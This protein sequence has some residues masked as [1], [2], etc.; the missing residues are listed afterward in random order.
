MKKAIFS[1]SFFLFI[2]ALALGLIEAGDRLSL[3]ENFTSSTCPPCA[4]NNPILEA[5]M[6][7]VDSEKVIAISYHMNWPTP[8]NDPMY[9]YNVTDNNGRRTFYN[10][11]S[12]PQYWFDGVYNQIGGYSG[13]T[14]TSQLNSRNAISSPVTVILTDSAYATDSVLV[15]VKVWCETY[16]SSPNATLQIAVLENNIAY[17]GTNGEPMHYW[18]M[19]KML[20]SYT[21]TQIQ[22][23]PGNLITIEQRY[24]KDPIWISNNVYNI[25]WVQGVGNEVYC[26]SQKTKNFTLLPYPAF[27]VV[28]QGVAANGSYKIRIPNIKAGY[29]S[30]VTFT[31]EVSP[32]TTGI[33]TSFPNGNVISNF[34]DSISLNVSSTSAVPTGAYKIIV[35]GTNANQKSHKI[36][37]DYLVGKNYVTVATN[38][39]TL[40][41]NVNGIGYYSSN[42]FSWNLGSSQTVSVTS[43]QGTSN[44]RYVFLNWSDG[45]DTSHPITVN[46]TTSLYTANFKTQ[47]YVMAYTNPGGLPVTISNG[48][49]F[50]DSAVTTTISVSPLQVQFNGKTYYFKRWMGGGNGSYTGTNPSFQVSLQNPINQICFYDTVNIGVNQ[51]GSEVPDKFALYQNYPNPFN[52]LTKIKFDLPKSGFTKI[53]IYDLTGK[54]VNILQNGVLTAGRYEVTLNAITFPSGVYFYKLVSENYSEIRKMILIK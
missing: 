30:P 46:N 36:S 40:N 49:M 38:P 34:Q 43:P 1:I 54:E 14:L 23:R 7:T 27:R 51:I 37:T 9:A 24:K 33:S 16:I 15:R 13:S 2:V 42:L 52:P 6:G 8:G 50:L 26:A 39:P 11:N 20:P 41:F 5:W 18:V 32:A 19:R 10:V 4:T 21:G 12:I 17:T 48:N 45:G 25:A 47:F 28:N 35:T 29:T 3:I 53:T 31:A 44:T 22:L